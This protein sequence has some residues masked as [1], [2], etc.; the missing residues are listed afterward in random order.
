MKIKIKRT[1]AI[2][3]LVCF[4]LSVT[5]TAVSA[6][7]ANYDSTWGPVSIQ[8]YNNAYNNQKDTGSAAGIAQGQ[9]DGQYDCQ[10]CRQLIP[11]EYRNITNQQV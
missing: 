6:Y 10:R 11:E 9:A 3:L 7:N 4:L 1:I 8:N 2:V 5:A